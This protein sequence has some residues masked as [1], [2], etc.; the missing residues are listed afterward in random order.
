MGLDKLR[1]LTQIGSMQLRFDICGYGSSPLDDCR[2]ALYSSFFIGDAAAGYKL[3]VS[4]YSSPNAA[5]DSFTQQN[6][7]KFSTYDQDQDVWSDNC[8]QV[9]HGGWWYN[10]CHNSNLN[11]GYG[12]T[13]YADGLSWHDW[14]EG[15]FEGHSNAKTTQ[16]SLSRKTTAV[17]I[18]NVPTLPPGE[19]KHVDR[20]SCEAACDLNSQCAV[21][22]WKPAET[23]KCQ[24]FNSSVAMYV[25]DEH[26][27]DLSKRPAA[28]VK[29]CGKG[30][31]EVLPCESDEAGQEDDVYESCTKT[32]TKTTGAYKINPL[33]ESGVFYNVI[34]DF[35]EWLKTEPVTFDT[36][37][38][39]T[40][41]QRRIDGTQDFSK[42]YDE[43]RQGF[44][45]TTGEFWSGNKA[46]HAL[47]RAGTAKLRVGLCED[48]T[49][50]SSDPTDM[51][52]MSN[53][54]IGV[55]TYAVYDSFSVAS[56]SDNFKLSV[57]GFKNQNGGTQPGDA[58]AYHNGQPFSAINK[59]LSGSNCV[60]QYLAGWWYKNCHHSNLNGI[61]ENTVHKDGPG[62]M[63][64]GD[65]RRPTRSFR[66]EMAISDGPWVGTGGSD[67]VTTVQPT[68]AEGSVPPTSSG[69]S[70]DGPTT[71]LCPDGTSTIDV[72]FN[73]GVDDFGNNKGSLRFTGKQGFVVYFTDDDSTG[74]QAD[75]VEITNQ[76]AGNCHAAGNCVAAQS[77]E[78]G[79]FVMGSNNRAG[80]G[81]YDIHTSGVVAVFNQGATKVSF[82]DT[83]D[84]GTLK[85]VF[86]F[87]KDGNFIGQ[88]AFASRQAVSIDTSQT[89]DNRLIYSLEFDTLQGTAGGSNDGTVFTIDNFHAEGL[90][91]QTQVG[92]NPK[93][94]C[95]SDC[96][97]NEF[98]SGCTGS[99]EGTCA[100]CDPANCPE[101]FFLTGCGG[102]GAGSC[103]SDPSQ[104]TSD[105]DA[106]SKA[107]A[108]CKGRE[109]TAI[110]THA[111]LKDV[112][113]EPGSAVVCDA[114]VSTPFQ[115]TD[116]VTLGVE[117]TLEKSTC[118]VDYRLRIAAVGRV[119]ARTSTSVDAV[120]VAQDCDDHWVGKQTVTA[121]ALVSTDW[122]PSN[123]KGPI[124]IRYTFPSDGAMICNTGTIDQFARTNA[125]GHG[126]NPFKVEFTLASYDS[127]VNWLLFGL[128][129]EEEKDVFNGGDY[130]VG[131][132]TIG[133]YTAHDS[134]SVFDGHSDAGPQMWNFGQ[135]TATIT[136]SGGFSRQKYVLERR[137]DGRLSVS[138]DGDELATTTTFTSMGPMFLYVGGTGGHGWRIT[139]MKLTET[140]FTAVSGV[141]KI[142]P[143]GTGEFDVYCDFDRADGPWTVFQRR[144]DGR[145]A[146]E[147]RRL[148]SFHIYFIFILTL[149]TFILTL[150]FNFYFVLSSLITASIS[151][152][153]T[154][155]I[156]MEICPAAQ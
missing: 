148:L 137:A 86:A 63:W 56:E 53:K 43:Y 27:D 84:D 33:K 29:A 112:S 120:Q 83:D 38:P 60:A 152:A 153:R 114:N 127:S 61:Y 49:C 13:G 4:G 140:K 139:D 101:G 144:F 79:G 117:Q 121:R 44:G 73:S 14:G 50:S 151:M 105:P 145:Y 65:G 99:S 104:A 40:I 150:K 126:T 15:S 2:S 97:A 155:N 143:G 70:Y 103:I 82:M 16:I 69:A 41:F 74:E 62:V 136:R 107:K 85:A 6:T 1:R 9:F 24:M 78:S 102:F 111:N 75:G 138:M 51:S 118:G 135:A 22:V 19:A 31:G 119:P 57:S 52:D 90:C 87:D 110:G 18:P 125:F 55:N 149:Y 3:T 133:I 42:T 8:A 23:L 109:P 17:L 81:N 134:A 80:V 115:I 77:A 129:S 21:F 132:H 28:Y 71:S 48:S 26:E 123:K 100:T 92:G 20:L 122:Q 30:C 95:R 89:T 10:A 156:K 47:T 131:R 91:A 76:Q 11:G 25:T 93:S 116:G 142:N 39:W 54:F 12:Y 108:T 96:A 58:L 66:T 106:A 46:L 124:S 45:E 32:P 128:G 5:G 154:L 113:I 72:N 36:S 94:P 7:A 98:V 147:R 146:W 59:D 34:C 64:S 68:G 37:N 67:S 35:G 141:Y 130:Q 88:S